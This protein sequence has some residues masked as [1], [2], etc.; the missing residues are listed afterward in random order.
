MKETSPNKKSVVEQIDQDV[1]L[2]TMEKTQDRR[3]AR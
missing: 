3:N 1:N 2:C